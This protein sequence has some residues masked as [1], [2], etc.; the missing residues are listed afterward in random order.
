MSWLSSF[1]HPERGYAAGQGQLDKYYNQ[2][3]GYQQPYNQAGQNA[4]PGLQEAQNNLLH[5]EQLQSQWMDSYETSPWAQQQQQ[6]SQQQGL[7]AASSMGLMGSQPALQAIQGGS[8]NIGMQDRQNY[9]NDLMQKY[10]AGTNLGQNI[11]GIGAQAGGQMGQRADQMGQ[12]SA[13]MQYNRTNAPGNML[14]GLMGTAAQ[15]G[16]AAMGGPIGGAMGAKLAQYMGAS[17]PGSYNPGSWST[18][19]GR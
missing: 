3:Q 8:A 7:D 16:G 11:Y 2:G 19:G 6:Q 18:T 15:L 9:L 14:G 1:L 4:L 10:Q 5:P 17:Q 13:Q 12:D